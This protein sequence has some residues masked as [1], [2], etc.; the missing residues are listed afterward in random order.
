MC[1]SR[2]DRDYE[3]ADGYESQKHGVDDHDGDKDEQAHDD[4]VD[5]QNPA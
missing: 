4:T 5:G 3:Y 2:R 1:G